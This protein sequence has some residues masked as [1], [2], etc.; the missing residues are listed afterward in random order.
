MADELTPELRAILDEANSRGTLLDSHPLVLAKKR[1]PDSKRD[2]RFQNI[3]PF[4]GNPSQS[5]TGY[6]VTTADLDEERAF[7]RGKR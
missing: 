2:L 6:G 5:K 1:S 4:W 3:K 7:L